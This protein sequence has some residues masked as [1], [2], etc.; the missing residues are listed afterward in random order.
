ML[1]SV[2]QACQQIINQ[3]CPLVFFDTCTILNVLNSVHDGTFPEDYPSH[4]EQ[5][6]SWQKESKISLVTCE[7]V[8]QEWRANI[9]KV[10]LTAKKAIDG[11]DRNTRATMNV[12]NAVTGTSIQPLKLAPYRVHAHMENISK[13]LLDTCIKVR[14]EDSHAIGAMHRVRNNIPPSR[15]GKEAKDCEIIECFLDLVKR[16]RS[17][18]SAEKAVFF[19]ANKNDFGKYGAILSPL[20]GD[21]N[22]VN[23]L[24][25]NEVN[26]LT[27]DILKPEK[28]GTWR[29]IRSHR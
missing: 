13:K 12:V 6:L 22:E 26:H 14:R 9:S 10:S 3:S 11:L 29:T 8:E 24:L 5:L 23:A 28:Q 7:T 18:G 27:S 1:T 17:E 2:E 4:I 20:D 19:T 25:F 21:F 15:H 16:L